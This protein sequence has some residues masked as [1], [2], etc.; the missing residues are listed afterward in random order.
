MKELR[1][2]DKHWFVFLC[3]SGILLYSEYAFIRWVMS[4]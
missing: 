4:Q 2:T 3:G 1:I